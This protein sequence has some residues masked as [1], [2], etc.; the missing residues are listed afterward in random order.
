MTSQ[1]AKAPVSQEVQPKPPRNRAG[2]WSGVDIVATRV[3]STF[4]FITWR[5]LAQII[6]KG[7]DECIRFSDPI[8]FGKPKRAVWWNYFIPVLCVGSQEEVSR[9][10]QRKSQAQPARL[11]KVSSEHALWAKTQQI[12]H[13]V[14][15]L[16]NISRTWTTDKPPV[17]PTLEKSLLLW[18]YLLSSTVPNMTTVIPLSAAICPPV[19]V[20]KVFIKGA[21]TCTKTAI[22]LCYP[23]PKS[24][25]LLGHFF[26]NA[27][28]SI[29]VQ[30]C[31]NFCQVFQ[32]FYIIAGC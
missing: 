7:A 13:I 20:P 29:Q 25:S 5:R 4:A 1:P 11:E 23:S 32:E 26:F 30:C 14:R 12:L 10:G 21:F 24:S 31:G 16:H 28:N 15:H 2:L 6:G 9:L 18:C 17:I 19:K 3:S 27:P 22:L 8:T